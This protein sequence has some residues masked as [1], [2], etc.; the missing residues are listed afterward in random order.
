MSNP[1][2]AVYPGT[3]D[4]VTVGHL[5]II[6]RGSRL[7][8]QLIVGVAKHSN[9]NP[10]FTL[11]ERVDLLNQDIDESVKANNITIMPFDGL[12]VDFLRDRGAGIVLRGLRSARDFDY[13]SQMAHVNSRLCPDVETMFLLS[14]PEYLTVSSTY[15]K[16]IAKLGGD[17]SSFVPKHAL[18][19]VIKKQADM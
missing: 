3:F 18:D 1:R 9:K 15:V 7:V 5:H 12:L 10:M 17:V 14:N 4:P 8:D 6:Q 11:E 2:I 19:A 13:E 16:Q